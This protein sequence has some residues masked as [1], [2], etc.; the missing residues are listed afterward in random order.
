MVINISGAAALGAMGSGGCDPPCAIAPCRITGTTI[1]AS[2]VQ[3]RIP[4]SNADTNPILPREE[5]CMKK[6]DM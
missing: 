2:A 1:L 3:C 4:E 6:A 5:F